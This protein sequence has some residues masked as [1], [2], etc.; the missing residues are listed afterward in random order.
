MTLWKIFAVDT[1]FKQLRKRS[2]K[3]I[4][5]SAGFEPVTSAPNS[6]GFIAQLVEH[7]TGI[8]EVTGSNPA[9]AWIFFRLLFRNCLN[10]V[11][12]AKIFHNVII[13][14]LQTNHWS[15]NYA[16]QPSTWPGGSTP[17]FLWRRHTLF[18]NQCHAVEH[19][20]WSIF[21]PVSSFTRNNMC[22]TATHRLCFD[23][24]GVIFTMSVVSLKLWT[25]TVG[26]NVEPWNTAN[27]TFKW[28]FINSVGLE[29]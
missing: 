27:F 12:T 29:A 24:S 8:A 26:L 15:I 9:E 25:I 23:S 4:Q 3:K 16:N 1:Q 14:R 19:F 20:T 17:H 7:C 13:Y 11:S 10:C 18:T 21:P 6:Y 22:N 5:A 2:L 28:K